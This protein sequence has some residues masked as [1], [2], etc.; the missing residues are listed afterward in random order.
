MR[1]LT[2][3]LEEGR[4]EAMAIRS[5]VDD[6]ARSW[7]WILLR[8][9]VAILFGFVAF[10]QPG[11]TL[12]ALT[13]VWGVYALADGALA[14]LAA[15][16]IRETGRPMWFLVIVG[17]LG[18]AAG[19]ITFVWPG[20]TAIVLLTFIA[21]WAVIAGLFQ[22]AAAVRLR[23]MIS[24][25]WML[26]LSGLLSVAFGAI[27]IARPGAGA[28]TVIWIIGWFATLYGLLLVM[29]SFRIKGIVGRVVPE[30]A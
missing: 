24:N 22:I 14:L 29:L 26:G 30:P 10:T 4:S 1:G 13:T 18:I 23:K 3:E 11:I 7:G 12:L 28:L 9:V 8:G 25:E 16:K 21:F 6:V 5:L 19:I 15:F 2:E 27:M 17:L 20:M